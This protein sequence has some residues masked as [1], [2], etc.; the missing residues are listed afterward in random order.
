MLLKKT[1]KVGCQTATLEQSNVVILAIK[2]P[3]CTLYIYVLL[4]P[5]EDIDFPMQG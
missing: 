3:A 1:L 5:V 4:F 2:D